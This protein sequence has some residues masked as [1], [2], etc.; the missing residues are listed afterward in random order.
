MSVHEV[1]LLRRNHTA[2]ECGWLSRYLSHANKGDSG[3]VKKKCISCHGGSNTMISRMQGIKKKK[4]NGMALQNPGLVTC[5]KLNENCT[6]AIQ[7][8]YCRFSNTWSWN[9]YIEN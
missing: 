3:I 7:Y 5:E 8:Y 1:F 2:V 9:L 4:K 6:L